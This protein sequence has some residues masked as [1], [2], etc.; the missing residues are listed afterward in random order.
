MQNREPFYACFS[1]QG[2]H[3]RKSE[4]CPNM[5]GGHQFIGCWPHMDTRYLSSSH[6]LRAKHTGILSSQVKQEIGFMM[7]IDVW[8]IS[9]MPYES[10]KAISL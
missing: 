7:D 6:A 9:D 4:A 2:G 8:F 10:Y 3:K 5:G 1:L